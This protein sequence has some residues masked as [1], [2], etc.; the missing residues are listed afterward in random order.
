[1]SVALVSA[2]LAEAADALDALRRDAGAIEAIEAGGALVAEVF[3]AG[4]RV[5]SCGNG[6]SMADAI[7]FAEE[8]TGRFRGDRPPLPATAIADSGH[9]SCTANDYGYEQVFARYLAAHGRRGDA[10]LAIS[11][12]GTSPNVLAAARGAR[13]RGL[14]VVGLTGRAASPLSGLSNVTICTPG[15]RYADRVQELHIK[16]IHILI[17]IVEARL[18]YAAS[19]H[20]A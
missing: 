15:G 13:E 14:L 19:A 17:E 18:G 9:L 16:V 5:F 12:S 4:G 7:H 6:G 1:M 11:T 10:L 2:A 3:A 8:L 20:R